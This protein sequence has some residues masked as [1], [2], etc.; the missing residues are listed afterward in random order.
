[1]EEPI[2][3]GQSKSKWSHSQTGIIVWL[4]IFFPVGLYLMWRYAGWSTKAKGIVTGGF[5]LVW[6]IVSA[7]G[8]S[9]STPEVANTN[10]AIATEPTQNTQTTP[11]QGIAAY[12]FDLDALYGKNIDEIRSVLGEPTDGAQKDPTAAQ[13]A[14]EHMEW[15]NTFEKDGYELLVTYDAT[16]KHVIDFFIATNDP[17]GQTKDVDSLKQVGNIVNS[18][19]Y[20]VEPVKTLSDPSYYTGITVTSK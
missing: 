19:H 18:E 3:K 4:I 10:T 12:V 1:M 17:S 14:F 8:N 11:E 6:I 9:T 13:M 5:V 20:I 15:S 2:Q 16:D 7:G